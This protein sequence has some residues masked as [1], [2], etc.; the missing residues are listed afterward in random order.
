M[1]LISLVFALLCAALTNSM[2]AR[3]SFLDQRT[4]AAFFLQ[5]TATP[6]P[7]DA[8]EIGSTDRIVAMGFILVGI[9]VIPILLHRKSWMQSQ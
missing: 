6:Q 4:N 7:Q 3:S 5:T 2:T 9:V 1:I 8:S